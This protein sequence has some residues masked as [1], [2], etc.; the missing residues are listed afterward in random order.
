M[1][2]PY[3]QHPLQS[4]GSCTMTIKEIAIAERR[5]AKRAKKELELALKNLPAP[6]FEYELAAI[7]AITDD[8]DDEG[9]EH[10]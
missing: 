6:Q 1:R 3:Q 7:N 5:A 4:I 10:G 9:N 8:D 2:Y